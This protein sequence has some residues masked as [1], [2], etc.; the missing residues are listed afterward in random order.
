VSAA[1]R[2]ELDENAFPAADVI[3]NRRF[4][5]FNELGRGGEPKT[6][7][8]H[9]LWPAKYDQKNRSVLFGRP[10]SNSR[11][12]PLLMQRRLLLDDAAPLLMQ[13][14]LLLDDAAQ[15]WDF[16]RSGAV[17]NGFRFSSIRLHFFGAR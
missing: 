17:S 7:K 3:V 5:Q 16:R 2:I 1:G 11:S 6:R 10:Y 9:E 12:A 14:W 8:E 15:L 13:R 4:G